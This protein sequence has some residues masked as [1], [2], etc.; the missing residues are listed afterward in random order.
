MAPDQPLSLAPLLATVQHLVRH[1]EEES[2]QIQR[3]TAPDFTPFQFIPTGEV[4]TTHL[5]A[6][7]LSARQTHGQGRLF[8]DL[9]IAQLRGLPQ[10]GPRLPEGIEW[11]VA[12][13][14]SC[15]AAGRL[16]LLLTAPGYP[17]FGICIE[18]K[19]RD[20][21]GDQPGQLTRYH[22]YLRARHGEQFLLLYLSRI[23]RPPSVDSITPD[24][25]K[26]LADEGQY[27]NI[28]YQQFLLPLLDRW[29]R[30]AKPQHLRRF[31]RQ[32]RHHLEQYLNLPSTKPASLMQNASI[33]AELQATPATVGAAFDIA[34]A[35]PTLRHNLLTQ[36][37]QALAAPARGLE[38]R[39]HWAWG[40]FEE[41]TDG[42]PFLIRRVDD[43]LG[44]SPA[45]WPWGR[46]AIAIEFLNGRLYCLLRY[47]VQHWCPA[48]L[49]EHHCTHEESLP[50][51]T[52]LGTELE[53]EEDWWLWWAEALPESA[54]GSR[55]ENLRAVCVA[56]A[57]P[58]S[59]LLSNLLAHIEWLARGLDAFCG[60]QQ[61]NQNHFPTA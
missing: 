16:D 22:D 30:A 37:M 61:S 18:N 23:P 5:L 2:R 10:L 15:G 36:L 43:R 31:L 58:A 50:L 11:A 46:Y 47:D 26:E 4:P 54:P 21:T 28:T 35:L 8:Q 53:V 6:F 1:V 25:L 39:L 45:N 38:G 55:D 14:K 12:A 51:A 20:Q 57:D 48:D 33:A 49:S 44:P 7:L 27:A 56:I 3:F 17:G 59:Q 41:G 29:R 13:E 9:L 34:A 52:I 60:S 42:K 40:G 19:P 32:F 24:L